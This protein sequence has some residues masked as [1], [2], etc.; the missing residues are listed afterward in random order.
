MGTSWCLGVVCV[1]PVLGSMVLVPWGMY[2]SLGQS[3]HLPQP[4][5]TAG[6][7]PHRRIL[8]HQ[9]TPQPSARSR[10]RDLGLCYH[11]DVW[12]RGPSPPIPSWEKSKACG[13]KAAAAQ[14]SPEISRRTLSFRVELTPTQH[15]HSLPCRGWTRSKESVPRCSCSTLQPSKGNWCWVL[16]PNR[17]DL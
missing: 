14:R 1:P 10:S 16:V 3:L 15:T 11:P 8:P 13:N 7:C 12:C 9:G 2:P 5:P 4:V 17:A 6:W